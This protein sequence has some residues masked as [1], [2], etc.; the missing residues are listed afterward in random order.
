MSLRRSR[1]DFCGSQ[2]RCVR[3]S[4]LNSKRQK[5]SPESIVLESQ[6][7]EN[8]SPVEAP[9]TDSQQFLKMSSL[10]KMSTLM[11]TD[12]AKKNVNFAKNKTVFYYKK[13]SCV[14][15]SNKK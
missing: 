3:S 5:E 13:K 6:P 2:N 12:S 15:S 4:K 1:S 9:L 14:S 7:T 10:K 11:Q 8:N